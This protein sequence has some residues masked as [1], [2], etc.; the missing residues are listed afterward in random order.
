[1]S[2]QIEQIKKVKQ[3]KR[4]LVATG[5]AIALAAGLTGAPAHADVLTSNTCELPGAQGVTTP[6]ATPFLMNYTEYNELP[7]V[8][9]TTPATDIAATD[10]YVL[11]GP[12]EYGGNSYASP[13]VSAVSP[14]F[15]TIP[16]AYFKSYQDLYSALY[17]APDPTNTAYDG[18]ALPTIPSTIKWVA[19]DP[20]NWT[21]TSP[22]DAWWTPGTLPTGTSSVGGYTTYTGGQGELGDPTAAMEGF[23]QLAHEFGYKVMVMPSPD[24]TGN[25]PGAATISDV[26]NNV[27]TQESANPLATVTNDP[28][29]WPNATDQTLSQAAGNADIY[30]IQAQAYEGSTYRTSYP[31]SGQT[32][33]EFYTDQAGWQAQTAA[34]AAGSS[35]VVFGGLGADRA[36]NAA[37]MSSDFTSVNNIDNGTSALV[38]GYWLNI[39]SDLP[40]AESFLAGSTVTP[41]FPAVPITPTCTIGFSVSGASYEAEATVNTLGGSPAATVVTCSACSGGHRVDNI[42][43]SGHGTLTVNDVSEPAAGSYTMAV[44]YTSPASRTAVITP[45]GI[46][47]DAQTV[48]FP[49]TYVSGGTAVVGLVDVNIPLT[50]SSTNT[51]EFA[52]SGTAAAPSFDRIFV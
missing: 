47:A 34:A 33:F 25:G 48:T 1:M 29:P 20:E 31:G 27:W 11:M 49:A 5:A 21:M 26:Q 17:N 30:E 8:T 36:P 28:A 14:P 50:A 37:D 6:T 32:Y 40:V 15:D 10:A 44:Y 42:G 2:K 7:G 3:I 12:S 35:V 45:N 39:P 13:V 43:T 52:G 24:L 22:S 18:N 46:T 16:V 19:Y 38:S 41:V 51:I 4:H 23:I 9:A